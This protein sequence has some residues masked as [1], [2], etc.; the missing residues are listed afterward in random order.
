MSIIQDLLSTATDILSSIVGV[1]IPTLVTF[2]LG[3]AISLACIIV[4]RQTF[5]HERSSFSAKNK[6]NKNSNKFKST[7][8]NFDIYLI[9]I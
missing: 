9:Q 7:K 5:I 1:S 2:Y 6:N 4:L 3:I 8:V